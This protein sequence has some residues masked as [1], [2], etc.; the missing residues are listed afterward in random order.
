MPSVLVMHGRSTYYVPLH[1]PNGNNVELS[2]WDPHELPYCT[3]ER[4]QAQL[5]AIYAKPQ[6]GCHKTLGQEYG[7]NGES[8]VCEI[9]SIHLFSSFP[10]EWMHLFLENHCKNMIKLWTGTFKGLNEGSGEFQ[11]SDVVWETIGTEMASS[12]ST[13]PSTFAC[14]TPNVWMEHHNFTAEDWAF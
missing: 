7:I 6:V 5:Q 4:H 14:H 9:P 13:I 8:D 10:H 1:Q 12:G 2:S 11:I 3:E